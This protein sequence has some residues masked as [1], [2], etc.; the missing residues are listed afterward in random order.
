MTSKKLYVGNL[1]YS[2]GEDELREL[3]SEAGEV[4]SAK[5]ITDET[6]RSKGFGF[7]EMATTE[8]A[9][10]AVNAINGRTISNRALNVSEA[11]PQTPRTGGDRPKRG[12]SSFGSRD[13]GTGRGWR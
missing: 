11:K 9:E 12:G 2:V 7:V 8:E 3:F 6:G 13:R 10:K 4:Q 1:P 5:V